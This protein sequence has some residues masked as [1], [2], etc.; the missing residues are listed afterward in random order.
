MKDIAPRGLC[1][2]CGGA[3]APDAPT[4]PC[5]ACGRDA[6]EVT[7]EQTGGAAHDA[8]ALAWRLA[9]L[10]LPGAWLVYAAVRWSQGAPLTLRG[11]LVTAA[12]LLTMGLTAYWAL[13]RP[14][15]A[16]VFHTS[17]HALLGYAV[18]TD[19]TLLV[20]SG[21]E[22]LGTP[23]TLPAEAAALTEAGVAALGEAGLAE[24]L[25]SPLG[26]GDAMEDALGE[27]SE[28][29]PDEAVAVA[30]MVARGAL[31]AY[32]RKG[33]QLVSLGAAE[34]KALR[35]LAVGE[36]DASLARGP[37]EASVLEAIAALMR[38]EADGAGT[39]GHYRAVA[40]LPPPE[41]CSWDEVVGYWE[42]QAHD[43]RTG[44]RAQPDPAGAEPARRALVAAATADP[45][46]VAALLEVTR[47]GR[48]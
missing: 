20:A 11:A 22:S 5:P 43:E 14:W 21:Y 35:Q 13:R 17:D 27:R 3:R 32:W 19:R 23:I 7:W 36:G 41:V 47:E 18:W 2:Y 12:A 42:E 45:D 8:E 39:L 9:A 38:E 4:A 44:V 48:Q 28:S 15:G 29:I 24:A 40:A 30:G 33:W 1:V 46:F 6:K 16:W 25:R 10:I 26:L 31:R 34:P 37:F